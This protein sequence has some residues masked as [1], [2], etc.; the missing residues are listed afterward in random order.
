MV[1]KRSTLLSLTRNLPTLAGLFYRA[2]AP[3]DVECKAKVGREDAMNRRELTILFAAILLVVLSLSAMAMM[4]ERHYRNR[5]TI[6]DPTKGIEDR[7]SA[8]E[9]ILTEDR[10]T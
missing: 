6:I 8:V 3:N 2:L 1:C 5:R 4:H 10:F 7:I 9:S